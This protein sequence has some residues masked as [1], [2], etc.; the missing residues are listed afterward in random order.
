ML[1]VSREVIGIRGEPSFVGNG[2]GHHRAKRAEDALRASE[3]QLSNA[4]RMAHLGHW[5]Y[6]IDKDLF[7]FNDHFYEIFR[8]TAEEV[9]G[10]TMSSAEYARRFVHPD[11]LYEVAYEIKKSLETTDPNFSQ[12]ATP[13]GLCG[14]RGWLH[15]SSHFRR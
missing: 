9:G 7:T 5:E 3:A 2:I 15:H 4:V 12:Q 14:R 11:D 1:F 13:H 10:Y 6:N 8:T